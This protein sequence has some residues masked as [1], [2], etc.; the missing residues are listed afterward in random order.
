M[1]QFRNIENLLLSEFFHPF[2]TNLAPLNYQTED[3]SPLL[4]PSRNTIQF[5]NNNKN[6]L[7]Y[8]L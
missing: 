4:S 5:N 8:G 1:D 3:S 7:A 2:L 6:I